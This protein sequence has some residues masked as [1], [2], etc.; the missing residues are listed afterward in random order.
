MPLVKRTPTALEISCRDL[1]NRVCVGPV[2]CG[3]PDDHTPALSKEASDET[4]PRGPRV[5]PVVAAHRLRRL[6][7]RG[8]HGRGSSAPTPGSERLALD[9][10]LTRGDIQIAEAHWHAFGFDPG[11][12]DGLLTA[13][14]QAAV[15]ASQARDG[16]PVS[17]LLDR[18]T[19]EE[20]QLRV[21]PWR[22]GQAG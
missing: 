21:D 22:R 9:R 1:T 6:S 19:H 17:G 15:Q 3:G 2:C 7:D 13:Q 16:L 4:V 14:T 20:L 10:L 11:P 5:A 12:I 8:I 18:A